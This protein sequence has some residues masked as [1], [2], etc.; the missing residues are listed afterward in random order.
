MWC[1]LRPCGRKSGDAPLD[2]KKHTHLVPHPPTRTMSVTRATE[3]ILMTSLCCYTIKHRKIQFKSINVLAQTKNNI[4]LNWNITTWSNCE[5]TEWGVGATFVL[6]TTWAFLCYL[7]DTCCNTI[8]LLQ[9]DSSDLFNR[10]LLQFFSDWPATSHARLP[11]NQMLSHPDKEDLFERVNSYLFVA[12]LPSILVL[13]V[14]AMYS[15]LQ[16]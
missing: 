16:E 13:C 12:T 9:L 14:R 15:I 2:L 3:L 6:P 11:P 1:H 5:V 4:H 10:F 7:H 8:S